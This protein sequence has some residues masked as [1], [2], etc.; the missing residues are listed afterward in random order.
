M[1]E[2]L[3]F[4]FGKQTRSR[5]IQTLQQINANLMLH[6]ALKGVKITLATINRQTKRLDVPNRPQQQHSIG[7]EEKYDLTFVLKRA[8]LVSMPFDLITSL[9]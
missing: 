3:P 5:F 1:G 7:S 2:M 4:H 8:C 6:P 9:S